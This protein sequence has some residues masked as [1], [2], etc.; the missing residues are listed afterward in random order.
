LKRDEKHT[1]GI[2]SYQRSSFIKMSQN[3]HALNL[4]KVDVTHSP[5]NYQMKLLLH[6]NQDVIM[7]KS[8]RPWCLYRRLILY[9]VLLLSSYLTTL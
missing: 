5:T 7:S 4:A 6:I 9:T 8:V 2:T 3:T 1:V